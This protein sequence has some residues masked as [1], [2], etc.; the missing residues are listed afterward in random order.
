MLILRHH[1]TNNNWRVELL[2]RQLRWCA[3]ALVV[4][5]PIQHYYHAQL[6]RLEQPPRETERSVDV[7]ELP[8]AA[9]WVGGGGVFGGGGGGF[10]EGW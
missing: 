4:A 5:P 1:S 3:R 8:D 6:Q 10:G 9:G 7:V 2:C